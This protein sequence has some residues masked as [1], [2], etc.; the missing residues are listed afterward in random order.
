[1]FFRIWTRKESFVKA[2][3]LGVFQILEIFEAAKESPVEM[4]AAE[5]DPSPALTD[6]DGLRWFFREYRF[7]KKYACSVCSA[8]DF[9]DEKVH[10]VRLKDVLNS[11]L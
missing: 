8:Q 9:F 4:T 5:N 1:M 11:F 3:G 6:P 2:T 7:D 10:E